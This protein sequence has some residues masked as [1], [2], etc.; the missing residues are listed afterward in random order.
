MS[1]EEIRRAIGADSL[2]YISVKGLKEACQSSRAR[3]CAGCFTGQFPVD[4]GGHSKRQ[5]E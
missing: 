4:V 5:F 1:L 2:G 3:F